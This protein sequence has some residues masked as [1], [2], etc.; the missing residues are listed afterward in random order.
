MNP[1]Q[2][3][4]REPGRRCPH[5]F[6]GG[7][8]AVVWGHGELAGADPKLE[9]SRVDVH[10][11]R[12]PDAREQSSVD[13]VVKVQQQVRASKNRLGLGPRVSDEAKGTR[14]LRAV[15]ALP[16]ALARVKER[17]TFEA[18]SLHLVQEDREQVGLLLSIAD[19]PELLQPVDVAPKPPQRLRVL[20][21][22]P[23]V[24]AAIREV[25]DLVNRDHD[26]HRLAPSAPCSFTPS[27]MMATAALQCQAAR[28]VTHAATI[29]NNLQRQRREESQWR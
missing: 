8:I 24:T 17:L 19:G 1:R 15:M 9:Q 20:H 6:A 2:A 3:A 27:S 16:L 23:E 21:V 5:G 13:R 7:Q 22:D 26:S 29:P 11:C 28:R 12:A 10:E 25:G 18:E 14:L 4:I